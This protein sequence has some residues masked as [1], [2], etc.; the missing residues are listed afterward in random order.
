[1][2]WL[3]K[4]LKFLRNEAIYKY[5]GTRLTWGAVV[6]DKWYRR[7]VKKSGIFGISS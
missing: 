4:L 6:L 2:H 7:G 3:Y 5:K 1:M